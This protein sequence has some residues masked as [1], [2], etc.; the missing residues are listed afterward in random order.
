MRKL[1]LAGK[2]FVVD[3]SKGE[4]IPIGWL[5]LLGAFIIGSYLLVN[6]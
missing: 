3:H 1:K 5:V 4:T 6:H 2:L